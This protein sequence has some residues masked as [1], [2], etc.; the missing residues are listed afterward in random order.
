MMRG[1]KDPDER[2]ED[3]YL[4]LRRFP[5]DEGTEGPSSATSSH[6]TFCLVEEIS[7]MRRQKAQRVPRVLLL[8]R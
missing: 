6:P 5:D 8:V 4:Q 7:M 3:D 1:Q 2:P